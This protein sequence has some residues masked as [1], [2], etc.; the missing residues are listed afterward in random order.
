MIDP[1]V[2]FDGFSKMENGNYY[3]NCSC[4]LIKGPPNVIV[5]TMTAWDGDKLLK[6]LN[7]ESLT[8]DDVDYVVCT[9]GHS[10]HIGCNYLF[11]KAKHIVGYSISH[12]DKY[13]IDH[14]FKN[15]DEYTITD[16]IKVISTPGHTLQD[17]SV[18][19]NSSRGVTA[20]TGDLFEKF[21]DLTDENI[22]K[23]AGSDSEELQRINRQKILDLADFIIP[24][25]GP[26]F[27]VPQ[28]FKNLG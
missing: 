28:K 22:W 5:D 16:R 10:D 13:D 9:H 21:E 2:L 19:V 14:D 27:K 25:H 12:K 7:K 1:I 11:Q 6:A 17:V 23:E 4:V 8:S 18:I 15:G 26:M 20:I 3:A 24:G